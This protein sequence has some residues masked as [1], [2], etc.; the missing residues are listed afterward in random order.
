M[1]IFENRR[2]LTVLTWEVAGKQRSCLQWVHEP[3]PD[4]TVDKSMVWNGGPHEISR[5][6]PQAEHTVWRGTPRVGRG[7]RVSV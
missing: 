6:D 2:Y 4:V 7:D 3:G 1:L 5:V